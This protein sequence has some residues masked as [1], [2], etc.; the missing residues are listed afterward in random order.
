MGR[1]VTEGDDE[2]A[3]DCQL[4]EERGRDVGRRG[5]HQNPV[6]RGAFGPAPGAVT[7]TGVDVGETQ[8]LKAHFRFDEEVGEPFHG[9]DSLCEPRQNRGLIATAGAD[10]EDDIAAARRQHGRHQRDDI[11]LRDR[12]PIADG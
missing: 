3:A 1:Q 6:E 8:P 7:Q 9:G 12:L 2:A 5:G 4:L 10:L 11:R